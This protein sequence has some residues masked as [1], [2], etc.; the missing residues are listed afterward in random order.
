MSNY[1]NKV[2]HSLTRLISEV[3]EN[4]S[5]F[6]RNPKSDFTRNRKINFKKFVGI[7]MN[8][9]GG[10]MSKELL[11]YKQPLNIRNIGPA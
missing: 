3:S 8:S 4:P 2:T 5:L 10:T 11:D 1:I 6:V 9:G 7:T